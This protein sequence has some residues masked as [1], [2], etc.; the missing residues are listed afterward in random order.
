MRN[1]TSALN[2]VRD[3]PFGTLAGACSKSSLRAHIRVIGA[4]SQRPNL[5]I[6]ASCVLTYLCA[7]MYVANGCG[8]LNLA[9]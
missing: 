9:L 2:S 1:G 7:D 3:P 6:S 5:P 8:D 4:V